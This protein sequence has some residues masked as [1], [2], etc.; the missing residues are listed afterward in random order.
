MLA[1]NE[2]LGGIRAVSSS[3]ANG[4]RRWDEELQNSRQDLL[5]QEAV[6]NGSR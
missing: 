4:E 6:R 1:R 5:L 2:A 3:Q